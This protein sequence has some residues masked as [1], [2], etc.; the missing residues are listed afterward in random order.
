MRRPNQTDRLDVVVASNL[1][2]RTFLTGLAPSGGVR[3]DEESAVIHQFRGARALQRPSKMGLSF[4]R[5]TVTVKL[6]ERRLGSRPTL[7]R[8]DWKLETQEVDW[9]HMKLGARTIVP[10]SD[11]FLPWKAQNFR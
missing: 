3:V 5:A 6:D 4:L 7:T 2:Q 1:T 9:C 10:Y 11:T 8:D